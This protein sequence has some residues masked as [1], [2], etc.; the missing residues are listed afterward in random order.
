MTV[1]VTRASQN[2]PYFE[3]EEYD[4]PVNEGLM[5]NT[6]ITTVTAFDP[7]P[8][9]VKPCSRVTFAFAS[10][11]AS[12]YTLTLCM[13]REIQFRQKMGLYPLQKYLGCY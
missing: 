5:Y 2:P 6:T 7:D 9:T 1:Q 8:G 11:S 3:Q 12:K 4:V 13:I 10:A